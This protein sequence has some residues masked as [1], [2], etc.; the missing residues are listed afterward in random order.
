MY[1]TASLK[2]DTHEKAL[3]APVEAVVRNKSGGASVYLVGKDNRIEERAVTLGM[4]TPAKLEILSGLAVNDVV[5]IGSRTQVKPG[6]LV[7]PKLVEAAKAMHTAKA[8]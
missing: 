4:E 5:M 6:E 2:L 8:E 1:A 7:Q 3:V